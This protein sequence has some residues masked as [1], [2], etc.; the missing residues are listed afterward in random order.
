MKSKKLTFPP[1]GMRILK[2]SIA[3]FLC[4]LIYYLTGEKGFV[5]Y[6]QLAALWCI[7]PY[8]DK[9]LKNALQRTV[10]TFVGALFAMLII[11]IFYYIFEL[12]SENKKFS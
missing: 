5:F 12:F 2:S 9:S 6:S 10:G 4:F 7:Q 3:V 11:P 8:V 1:I